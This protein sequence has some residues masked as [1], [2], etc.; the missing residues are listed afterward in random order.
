MPVTITLERVLTS[1]LVAAALALSGVAVVREIRTPQTS[2]GAVRAVPPRFEQNWLELSR[3]GTWVGDSTAK[4]R[5]VEFTDLECPFCARFHE[6]YRSVRDSL[7]SAVSLLILPFPIPGHR[8]ARPAA[9]AAE[10]AARQ[11]RYGQF[12]DVVFAKQDSLG[13]KSWTGFAAEAGVSDTLVFRSCV[14]TNTRSERIDSAF[15]TGQRVGVAGTP[16]VFIEGWRYDQPPYDSLLAIVR[17]RL[18]SVR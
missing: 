5:I 1:L 7:G 3:F 12:H 14:A 16:T 17:S 11:G 9:L 18:Q 4:V 10:C 8:F 13:L 6:H 15:A 2:A